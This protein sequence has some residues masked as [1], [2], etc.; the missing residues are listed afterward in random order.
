MKSVLLELFQTSNTT[1]GRKRAYVPKQMK[2]VNDAKRRKIDTNGKADKK[3]QSRDPS[4]SRDFKSKSGKDFSKKNK[5]GQKE[6]GGKGQGHADSASKKAKKIKPKKKT[7]GKKK[8]H[9][10]KNK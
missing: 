6:F 5:D 1:G 10:N 3:G 2:K 7:K 9:R 8:S 4:K